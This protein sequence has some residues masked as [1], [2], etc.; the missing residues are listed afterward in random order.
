M[1]LDLRGA[2]SAVA[3]VIPVST[4]GRVIRVVGS[5]VEASGLK[6]AVGELC[7]IELPARTHRPKRRNELGVACP[8]DG[9]PEPD[10]LHAQAEVIGFHRDSILLMPL[11]E[12]SGICPGALVRST[13]RPLS[14][15]VGEGLLGRILDGLGRPIDGKGSVRGA[16]FRPLIARAPGPLDRRRI[17]EPLVTGVRAMDALLTC[18]Q[19]QRMGIFA[20][21]GIGKSVLLGSIARHAVADV[22]VIALIGERGREVREF[23]ERDLGDGLQRSIVVVATSDQPALLRIKG[24]L[25][26]LTI[27]EHFREQGANVLFMM[28]SLT[29]VAMAQREI[30]LAAGE[31]PTTKGYPPSVFSLMPRLLER[32][33]TSPA[34]TITGLFAVLVEADDMNEPVSD[35]A[36]SILDG[37]I[38]LSR[39]LAQLGHYPAIDVLGSVSRVMPDVVS[40][41]HLEAATEIRRVLAVHAEAED[42]INLGAYVPGSNPQVDEAI[43]RLPQIKSFLCQ[44]PDEA[45][46]WKETIR[47]VK[48]L[49]AARTIPAPSEEGVVPEQP[50]FPNAEDERRMAAVTWAAEQPGEESNAPSPV[51]TKGPSPGIMAAGGGKGFPPP[52]R[53]FPAG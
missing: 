35:A 47:Q 48:E 34:G 1:Q 20:G 36:R 53:F 27:A 32:V 3:G 5:V 39:R 52:G 45:S 2:Y 49:G 33:G 16:S 15:R 11:T 12:V 51:T 41:D 14:V 9:A 7:T 18:G 19:G 38:T 8:D 37:H 4:A 10:A 44:R 29:R 24:T 22:N 40:A 13:L 28:D 21:S 42:V 46:L 30:G 25:V 23:L 31:P 6:A 50:P 17:R 43:A 26:A